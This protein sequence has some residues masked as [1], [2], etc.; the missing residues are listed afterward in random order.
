MGVW[1]DCRNFCR[2]SANSMHVDAGEGFAL[3][4]FA[5]SIQCTT[6]ECR[7]EKRIQSVAILA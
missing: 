7:V 4:S 1:L 5:Y 6:L 3:A 2:A